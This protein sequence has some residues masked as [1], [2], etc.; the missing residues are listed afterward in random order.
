MEKRK[1]NFSTRLLANAWAGHMFWKV[2][3][4][5]F[6]PAEF[7]FTRSPAGL[8]PAELGKLA[9]LEVLS[10]VDNKTS[11]AVSPTAYFVMRTAL[12]ALEHQITKSPACKLVHAFNHKYTPQHVRIAIHGHFS[13]NLY[14]QVPHEQ[15][16]KL[17]QEHFRG[18]L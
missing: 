14:R 13:Q 2:A 18:N 15:K 3:N 4:Y 16:K 5:G 12:F 6:S 10:L 7:L 9:A 11:S 8:I 17:T 1:A